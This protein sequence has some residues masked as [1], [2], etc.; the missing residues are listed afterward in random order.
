MIGNPK[1]IAV[2]PFVNISSDIE[3]EYFSDGI[4]EEIL[5]ALTKIEGLLVTARTSSF[6]FK[7]K[8]QDIC[9]IGHQLGVAVILEG[10]VRKDGNKVRITAQLAKTEEGYF[11]WSETWDRDLDDIFAVQDEIALMIAEKLRENLR[12]LFIE[13]HLVKKPTDNIE[14]YN[15][16]L[17]GR[18]LLNKWSHADCLEAI[19][20]FEKAVALE[21]NFA[22]PYCGISDSYA[23]IGAKGFLKPQEVFPKA[24]KY[25]EKALKID[26]RLSDSHLALASVSFWYDWDLN[27]T[28][29]HL[30]RAIELNYSNADAHQIIAM[31]LMAD[32]KLTEAEKESEKALQLD[33]MSEKNHFCHA[34]I[35][36]AQRKFEES[37]LLM[38]RILS[39]N[40]YFQSASILKGFVLAYLKQYEEAAEL[41]GNIPVA[42]GKTSNYI[43]GSGVVHAMMGNTEKAME[44]YNQLYKQM[45]SE[46]VTF[47]GHLLALINVKLEN[48][49]EAFAIL[50]EGIRLRSAEL[51]YLK[52]HPFWEELW[53]DP[54]YEKLIGKI[55]GNIELDKKKTKPQYK[56]SGLKEKDA[57]EILSRLEEYMQIDKPYLKNKL[58]LNDLSN[59]IGAS[60][61]QLSQVLNEQLQQNFYDYVNGFRLKEFKEKIKNPKNQ[62][63][64]FLSVAY[65]CG[66]NSKTTFNTFFKKATGL[67]PSEYFKKIS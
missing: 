11:F 30:E 21:P 49:D 40:P 34:A 41:F 66:F 63:F 51:I 6:T 7:G 18:Y 22:L 61:N 47:V 60:S 4:T 56:K 62:K 23:F 28:Y 39:A 48:F 58:T 19:G 31:T 67:T 15:L 45:Q 55:K 46:Q 54:R 65:Q 24:R 38:D 44:Y 5:N 64:T 32:Q 33:P 13:D 20:L 14:A 52:V 1:S 9:S 57:K 36:V 17:Q 50:E 43:G 53:E 12:H 29:K 27:T 2:I 59:H 3:N 16:Y 37:I 8:N 42:P 25:A 35:Y 26:D 10:S